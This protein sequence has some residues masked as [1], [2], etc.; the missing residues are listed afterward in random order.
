MF[1]FL[2]NLI[3][4]LLGIA[5]A[6]SVFH[7]AITHLVLLMESRLAYWQDPSQQRLSAFILAR[8][9]LLE[10]LCNVS[11]LILL[12]ISSFQANANP[13][14]NPE[15]QT[16]QMPILLIHGYGQTQ[17]DWY[18]FQYQLKQ[19]G[20]GPVYTINL[21]NVMGGIETHADKVAKR[22]RNIQAK[23]PS[24][25][26]TL[27][28]HSMGGLVASYYAEF[29]T[30][31]DVNIKKIIALGSPLYGTRLAGLGAGLSVEQMAPNASFL[32]SLR[33]KIESSPIPY[34]FVAS[35]MD[36]TIV[37]WDSALI[38]PLALDAPNQ[39]IVPDIGHLRL[40]V[41]TTVL[42]KVKQWL[43]AQ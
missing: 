42:D 11:R 3:I 28:G 7:A 22:I 37:P 2:G 24:D 4:A 5:V 35:Q 26:I 41:S 19:A 31:G 6:Y 39:M 34:Y 40:L 16:A 14:G 9:A 30:K 36:N 12:P 32:E 13:I 8:N 1:H 43:L 33:S 27:I 21:W 23:H 10:C 17:T 15:Q 20:I 25:A 38:D 18:W 29:L